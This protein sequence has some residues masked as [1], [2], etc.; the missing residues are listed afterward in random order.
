MY[1]KGRAWIEINKSH[2]IHNACQLQALLPGSCVMMP[3][4]K[5]NAYGHGAGLIG[6]TLQGM[7]VTDFCVASVGEGVELRSLGITGQILV[8]SYTHPSQFPELSQYTLTQTVVDC[9]YAETLNA[10][11][12]PL[13]VHVGIDTGMHRLGERSEKVDAICRIWGFPNLRIT[14]IFSHLCVSDG[15]S[16]ED[17]AYTLQ[18]FGRFKAVT[19]ALH[20]RGIHGFKSH[21]QSSYGVLNYPTPGFDYARIGIALYGILS[22]SHDRTACNPQLKPVLTLKARIECVKTLYPGEGAGYGLAFTA[23]SECRIAVVSIGYA[24]GLPRQLSGN[25]FALVRGHKI[26]IIG[27]ICMDQLFLNVS[28]I[29]DITVGDEAVFIGKSGEFEIT[30]C[31]VADSAGTISNELLSRLGSRL[32]RLET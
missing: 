27:R 10:Y 23:S 3:A 17:R 14:G 7:G 2:L 11:G 8:L 6:K 21:I 13:C 29:P 4:V 18:Q 15:D 24:D 22:S 16:D 12:S 31:D 25:G 19:D 28:D 1:Q 26:P 32:E 5:A 20:G 30:A 9:S